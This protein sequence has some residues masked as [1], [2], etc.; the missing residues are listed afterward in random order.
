M[1]ALGARW[2]VDGAT[3]IA[4]DLGL[5]D[6]IVGLTVVAVGT[7]LPEVATSIVAALKGE[8]DIAVGNAVGSNIFNILAVLGI[9]SLVSPTAIEVP[10]AAIRFDLP[11]MVV[12]AVATLPIFFKGIVTR[13]EGG[14]FLGYYLAYAFYT[15][16]VASQHDAIGTFNTIMLA[17][18][19]PLT[20]LTM[21]TIFYLEIRA[22]RVISAP[23]VENN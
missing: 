21:V 11:V 15:V 23:E 19:A 12:V 17:F 9:A 1:L 14:L 18:V 20:V 4:L 16:L 8:R 6:L 7:S 22:R 5:S 10:T 2:L 13:L 3:V